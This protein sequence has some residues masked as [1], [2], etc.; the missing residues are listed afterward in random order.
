MKKIN[1]I[2]WIV[3]GIV[4]LSGF[5][6]AATHSGFVFSHINIDIDLIT[7]IVGFFAFV[8]LIL[9]LIKKN[10]VVQKYE[11]TISVIA[12]LTIASF[13]ILK[14]VNRLTYSTFVFGALHIQPDML[15]W[16]ALV[17]VFS[18][19]VIWIP[20][21]KFKKL[22]DVESVILMFIL[23]IIVSNLYQIYKSEWQ[24]F[25][26]MV[27]NPDATYDDKMR[28]ELCPIFYDYTLFINEYTS[29]NSS[30]LMPP[31]SFPWP[32]VGNGGMLRYFVYPRN[33]INGKEYESP[34]KEVLDNVDYVLLN[35]GETEQTQGVYTQEWPKF[36]VKAEKIIFMNEDGSF[37]GEVKGDY[38]YSNYKGKK[39][40]G[41]I[42]VKH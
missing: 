23:L 32:Y 21:I 8:V 9:K 30:L 42:V 5:V 16:P 17:A 40:W 4:L 13:I 7:L 24:D 19:A 28:Y 15:K 36:D 34:S 25:R 1:F 33:I 20:R 26:Y 37:G 2:F 11:K 35:W 14:I 39:V 38:H 22:F 12:V 10:I 18:V 41:L 6:E 3:W 31:Q 27:T 29:E